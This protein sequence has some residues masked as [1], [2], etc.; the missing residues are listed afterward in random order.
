MQGQK[1]RPTK[2]GLDGAPGDVL[3]LGPNYRSMAIRHNSVWESASQ[4]A[5]DAIRLA[6]CATGYNMFAKAVQEGRA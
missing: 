3:L 1:P 6:G 2:G 4:P 5:M